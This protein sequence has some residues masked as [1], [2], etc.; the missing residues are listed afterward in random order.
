MNVAE[1][2][3]ARIA[4]LETAV[5]AAA[6]VVFGGGLLI[7]PTDT[8]YGIGCDPM[9]LEA[10]DRIYGAKHRPGAKPLTLHLGSVAEF[11]EHAGKNALAILAA[12]R[13]LPG[14]VT[15]IVERPP[16]VSSEM[17]SG[18]ATLGLRVP[19]DALALAILDRCG[20]LAATSAN[21]SGEQ[22]YRGG[23]GWERLPQ[24]DLL[25]ENGPTRHRLESTVLDLTGPQARVLREGVVS[26]EELTEKLGP[27]V[28]A[29]VKD[30]N[31]TL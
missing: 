12:K 5:E 1:V 25:I 26:I 8:V 6:R 15:L 16:F 2:V 19:D 14:P 23:G 7:F 9:D 28:R 13:L 30:R 11:L 17:T 18:F 31:I 21:P 29:A 4:P 22:S 24:A 10:I 27:V 3:D 20:P